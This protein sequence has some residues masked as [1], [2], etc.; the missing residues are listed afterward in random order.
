MHLA[1]IT[2]RTA[3]VV[4]ACALASAALS[5]Y[6]GSSA[7]TTTV[8]GDA[9]ASAPSATTPQTA[10]TAPKAATSTTSKTTTAT[11]TSAQ[12]AKTT[13]STAA[14]TTTSPAAKTSATPAPKAPVSPTAAASEPGG[15]T[16]K[17]APQGGR[18]SPTLVKQVRAALQRYA[19][20]MRAHGVPLSYRTTSSGVL[21]PSNKSVNGS[22]PRYIAA[23][24]ACAPLLHAAFSHPGATP[25]L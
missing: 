11:T 13:T 6:G 25:G 9:A 1:R 12:A 18:P 24:R 8:S 15:V 7:S 16:S 19:A 3:T 22:S 20:C 23:F 21:F 14:K 2:P 17:Q 4:L 10:T 5:A